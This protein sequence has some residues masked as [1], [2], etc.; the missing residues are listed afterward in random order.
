[1]PISQNLWVKPNLDDAAVTYVSNLYPIVVEEGV[2]VVHNIL[3]DSEFLTWL[4]GNVDTSHAFLG[5]TLIQPLKF[6]SMLVEAAD[7]THAF[8]S[9]SLVVERIDSEYDMLPEAVDTIHAQLGG[10][11]L[12]IL[13]FYLNWPVENCDVGHS[14]VGGTLT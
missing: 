2:D 10:T 14:F 11:L 6:Y 4:P 8:I 7:V 13:Y 3:N 9:G 5:G 1:M 12:V